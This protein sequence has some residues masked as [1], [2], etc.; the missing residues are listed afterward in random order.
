LG[1]EGVVVVVGRLEGNTVWR[2]RERE[3]ESV[4]VCVRESERARERERERESHV[5]VA[6]GDFL[7]LTGNNENR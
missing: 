5:M 1:G 2:E 6:T 4:C 7:M 3:R